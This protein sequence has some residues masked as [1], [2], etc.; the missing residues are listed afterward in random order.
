MDG[1][2]PISFLSLLG[3]AIEQSNW[4]TKSAK[5]RFSR[6]LLGSSYVLVRATSTLRAGE[7]TRSKKEVAEPKV[8]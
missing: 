6:L 2:R 8:L 5:C 3:G 1:P 4:R 7:V